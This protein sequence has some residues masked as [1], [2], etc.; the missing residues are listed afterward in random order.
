MG[1][2]IIVS[3]QGRAGWSAAAIS[4]AAASAGTLGWQTA[5]MCVRGLPSG[6]RCSSQPIR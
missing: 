2:P 3:E 6:V 5:S 4:A 1:P